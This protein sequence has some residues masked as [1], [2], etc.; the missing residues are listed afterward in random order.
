[1]CCCCCRYCCCIHIYIPMD[2]CRFCFLPFLFIL[3]CSLFLSMLSSTFRLIDWT[4]LFS[5]PFFTFFILFIDWLNVSFFH[6]LSS[7]SSTFILIDWTSLFHYLSSLSSTFTLIDWMSL[8]TT[9]LHFLHP[10][11][12]LIEHRFSLPVFTFFNLYIDWL[13]G[14]FHYLSSLSSTFI[15]IDWT[16]L[17][18]TFHNF[19]TFIL[20]DWTSLFTTFLHFLQPLD[21]LIERLFSL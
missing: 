7:L 1:M 11:Y 20:I 9:C 10:L 15:L 17:F 4:S 14:S 8:F 19:S 6:Y 16:S 21:W 3:L 18:T 13:H 12:W 5:L 2:L